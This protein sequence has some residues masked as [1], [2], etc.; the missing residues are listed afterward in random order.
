MF[1]VKTRMP[2]K[3]TVASEKGFRSPMMYQ[4]ICPAM[5]SWTRLIVLTAV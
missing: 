1:Q 3:S 5:G 2:S 4:L